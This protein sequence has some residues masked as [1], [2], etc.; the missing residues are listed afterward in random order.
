MGL[1]ITLLVGSGC[2]RVAVTFF[3]RFVNGGESLQN[4]SEARSDRPSLVD[5]RR[6]QRLSPGGSLAGRELTGFVRRELLGSFPCGRRR[7]FTLLF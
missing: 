4:C 1:G 2:Q 7:P 6:V 3:P 5:F